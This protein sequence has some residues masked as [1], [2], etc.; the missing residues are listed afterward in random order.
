MSKTAICLGARSSSSRARTYVYIGARC[1]YCSVRALEERGILIQSV[2][3]VSR[4]AYTGPVEPA[5]PLSSPQTEAL[6]AI[7]DQWLTHDVCL[8]HGVTSSGKT[9]VYIHLIQQ[10]LAQQQSVLY[11]VPEIALTTQLTDRLRRVFGSH[12]V[13]YHSR[14]SNAERV[15]VYHALLEA[16]EPKV[17]IGVRSA[18]F[19]PMKSVGLIIVDEEHET[20]YK[21]Q[22]PSPR[23]HAR[24]AAIMLAQW[25]QAKVLLGTATPSIESYHNAQT[26]KYGLV[27]LTTRYAGLAL[28]T[29]R[30]INLQQQYH[31]KEMYGHFADPLVDRIREVL[32]AG[33]Q[34]ILFQ[35]RRG[36]A[37]ML[38]CT[39]C[40]HP[41]RCVQCD[42]PLTLHK[43]ANELRCH[44]CGYTHPLMQICPDCGG[45][46]KVRGFG[47]ERLEDEVATLF[48]EARVLRM[49]LDTTRSKTAY[50][51][52][53]NRF[54]RHDCDILIGTQ[55][56]TK[57]L[58]FDDVALVAVLNADQLLNQSDFR[59]FERSFQMLS[60]VAGRAGRKGA[61]G[62]VY[63]QTFDPQQEVLQY[64]LQ[65]DY[66]SLYQAQ[67]QERQMFRYPPFYRMMDITLR[68][69]NYGT[70]V[71][72]ALQLQQRLKQAFGE[73]ISG[74]IVPPV[75]RVQNTHIRVLRLRIESSANIIEAKRLLMEQ[76]RYV[77]TMNK[78]TYIYIDVDPQ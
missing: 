53:I 61:Q 69:K 38:Q 24:S 19:L 74:V 58:H 27:H 4:I 62:E 76:V 35:N 54:S 50:Q 9:E 16:T 48:P 65:H 71:R 56:V 5:H 17:I 59:A 33:K 68:H 30:L 15:E 39:Q 72:A 37:P 28:P 11:L 34:V 75:A 36:Y 49:D 52:I 14:L 22:D 25:L 63:I 51:D 66:D 18:V 78:S 8:L 29:I 20:S 44:W 6:Q 40:G 77:Q 47:T 60:Q 55:M 67:I 31:R 43:Q 73:R 32:A 70:V 3:Q 41:P 12:L 64:V 10:Q 13:V 1:T 42:V 2:R 57:G 46:L 21:Q 7:N 26:G 23:Y 45:E